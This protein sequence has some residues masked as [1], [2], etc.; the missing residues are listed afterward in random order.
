MNDSDLDAILRQMATEHRPQLPSPGLIWFR[1][2]IVRKAWQKQ[3]IER[4]LVVM[5]GLAG[6][7][8]A[9]I[10]LLLV[11]G[12]WGQMRD[13]M[14]HQRWFLLP[15]LLLTLT[16]CSHLGRYFSGPRQSGDKKEIAVRQARTPR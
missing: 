7:T 10:L 15:L 12:N 13:A 1:A 11:A 4:P 14:D 2:Q 6:I 9:V 3:R 8:G 16:L 5:R